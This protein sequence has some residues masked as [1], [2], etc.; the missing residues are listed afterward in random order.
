MDEARKRSTDVT[1]PSLT[2]AFNLLPV[3]IFEYLDKADSEK[4][5]CSPSSK[6]AL[7]PHTE[8]NMDVT[9]LHYL[10]CI[11]AWQCTA[12]SNQIAA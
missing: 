12:R 6:A 5:Q 2:E 3:S 9:L 4:D 10:L 7:D 1:R 11:I 8:R